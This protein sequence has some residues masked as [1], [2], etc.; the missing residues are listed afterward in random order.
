MASN[1]S[2][3]TGGMGRVKCFLVGACPAV[4][5]STAGIS[6]PRRPAGIRG[7]VS[8]EE[9]VE[10]KATKMKIG[11]QPLMIVLA[12]PVLPVLDR[13]KSANFHFIPIHSTQLVRTFSSFLEFFYIRRGNS[14]CTVHHPM[15]SP[16]HT[17]FLAYCFYFSFLSE[18]CL[19]KVL[20]VTGTCTI[21]TKATS[22]WLCSLGKT[23]F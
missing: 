5:S 12:F 3:G 18:I 11:A 7:I 23:Y 14:Y 19:G 10:A 9:A 1:V 4:K 16:C 21:C 8:D 20:S 17:I 6:P 13:S 15:I 22:V 2:L